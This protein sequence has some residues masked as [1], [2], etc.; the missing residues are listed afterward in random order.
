V[1]TSEHWARV[2]AAIA[3]EPADAVPVSL[4][5]HFPE[6]DLEAE[7]LAAATVTWQRRFD[8]DFVKLMPPGDYPVIAWGGASEYRGN[9]SGTRTVTRY[10]VQQ[11]GDWA[12]VRERPVD[13]GMLRTVIESA[14]LV[15]QELR[16]TV[17]VLQTIFSPL[18]VAFK[19]SDGRVVQDIV[20]HPDVVAE[21]LA[22]ITRTMRALVRASLDAGA[23]G[24]FFA[25][26]CATAD[27]MDAQTYA[28]WGR[29]WDLEVLAEAAGAPIVFLH[30]HG[31]RPHFDLVLDYPANVLNWHDRRAGPTLRE[32]QRRSGRCVAGGIDE[33]KIA[34]RDP[35]AIEAE[36]RDALAQLDGRYLMVTPGCVIPVA[37]P[38]TNVDAAVRA[39]RGAGATPGRR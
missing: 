22:A 37:T 3:G 38:E 6:R 8:F 23:H 34:E 16:G 36:A 13:R 35:A 15:V 11:P 21:A 1:E 29:S 33:S 14:R 7:S 30:V 9:P 39:V 28:R 32:G 18:T 4:W 5:R 27:V 19:L 17:P 31:L 24:I 20:E 2:R 12:T 25:T 10:P 26:Q